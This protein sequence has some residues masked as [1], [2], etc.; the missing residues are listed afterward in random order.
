MGS[1]HILSRIK[2][3][4]WGIIKPYFCPRPNLLILAYNTIFYSK[5]NFIGSTHI[6]ARINS[7]FGGKL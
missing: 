7:R 4:S 1:T 6:L 3:D 2:L 5:S